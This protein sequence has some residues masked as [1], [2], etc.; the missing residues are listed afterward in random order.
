MTDQT[1]YDVM[2]NEDPVFVKE[3]LQSENVPFLQDQLKRTKSADR[4]AIILARIQ[5]LNYLMI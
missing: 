3:I 5:K 1:L 4:K 2:N